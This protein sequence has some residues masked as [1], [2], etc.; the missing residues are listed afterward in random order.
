MLLVLA[1]DMDKVPQSSGLGK[2]GAEKVSLRRHW[3]L[4]F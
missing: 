4:G 1:G 3:R 2:R